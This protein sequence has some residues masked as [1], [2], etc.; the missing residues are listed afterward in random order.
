MR[1]NDWV[2]E[3]DFL[4]KIS[5][6]DFVVVVSKWNGWGVQVRV[7]RGFSVTCNHSRV[8]GGS[9]HSGLSATAKINSWSWTFYSRGWYSVSD[10]LCFQPNSP[11]NYKFN[12]FSYFFCIFLSDTAHD[13]TLFTPKRALSSTTPSIHL[14]VIIAP[15]LYYLVKSKSSV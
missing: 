3:L 9:S 1:T 14:H 12:T 6:V 13:N 4:H 2:G 10:A 5:F 11:G 8:H 7:H 15:F